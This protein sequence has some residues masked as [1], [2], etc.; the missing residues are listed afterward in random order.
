V[1]IAIRGLCPLI[2][3]FDMPASLRFYR[4][5]LGFSEVEKSGQG[6][7]VGWVWLRHD[8]ACLM[9]NT[10]YDVG[11]RPGTPDP[12]RVAGHGDTILFLGCEDLDGAHAYLAANG[13]RADP[14]KVAPYGMK[15]LHLDDPDGY[16]VCLQW[17]TD[18]AKQNGR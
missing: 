2:Q 6:D 3:V 7:D 14:P 4:D 16:G 9:L 12:S 8:D 1:P 11:E 17:P 10:A 13:V 15:Q 18:Q 5:I